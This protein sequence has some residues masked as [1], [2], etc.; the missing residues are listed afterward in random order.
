MCSS[1]WRSSASRALAL[2]DLLGG[3]V[4][5]RNFSV[6]PAQRMPIG[7][8]VPL[9]AG[10]VR[11]LARHLNANDG[12]AGLHDRSDDVF[13]RIRQRGDGVAHPS[14][15]MVGDGNA[16]D[17]GEVL[18]DVQIAAIRREEREADRRG[19]VD[20]LQRGRLGVRALLRR[21]RN[22]DPVQLI[23]RHDR[24]LCRLQPMAAGGPLHAASFALGGPRSP[25]PSMQPQPHCIS[26]WD[27]AAQANRVWAK[28]YPETCARPQRTP[29]TRAALNP[30]HRSA[31]DIPAPRSCPAASRTRSCSDL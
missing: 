9:A 10:V 6:R 20:E 21:R 28:R 25:R 19:L 4:H 17:L 13:D 11:A 30:A 27:I 23:R 31:R 12:L 29:S 14:P 15:N 1:R 18:I 22:C 26:V 8:P 3:D 7:H 5:A 2:G 16:A 24:P